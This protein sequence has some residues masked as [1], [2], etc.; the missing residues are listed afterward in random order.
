MGYNTTVLVLN[1]GLNEIAKDKDFGQKIAEAT[2]KL[3]VMKGPLYVPAG[4]HANAASVIETHHAD[5]I[6][7]FAVG[8]N[9]VE[10]LGY[11]GRYNQ[12]VLDYLHNLADTYG[13]K[14]VKKKS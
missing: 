12:K 3:Q 7:M 1:D 5:D 6:K 9:S 2:M 13:Y 8:G 10:D 14:L 4:F 11:V